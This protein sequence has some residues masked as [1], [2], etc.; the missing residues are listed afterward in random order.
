MRLKKLISGVLAGL[1]AISSIPFS[2]AGIIASAADAEKDVWDGTTDT[3]WYDSE[4]TEFHISTPEELAGLAE[5]VN[6]GKSMSGQT[7]V[8]DNDIYMN[9]VSKYEK[10]ESVAP[11]NSWTPIGTSDTY[12]F[13]GIFD[14]S[15]FSI[16]GLYISGSDYQ[17]SGLLGYTTDL[18]E[19]SNINMTYEYINNTYGNKC[20]AGGI[21]AYSKGKIDNCIFNGTVTSSSSSYGG[22]IAGYSTAEISNCTNNGTVTSSSDYNSYGGGIAGYSSAEI[23]NCTNSG[24]VTSSSSSSSYGGGIAGYSSANISNCANNGTITSSYG[25]GIVGESYCPYDAKEIIIS[26]VYNTG[27]VSAESYE[28]GIVGYVYSSSPSYKLTINNAYNIGKVSSA[29]LGG[30]KYSNNFTIINSSYLIGQSEQGCKG[31]TDDDEIVAKS[32]AKM[33]TKEFAES[34]GDAFKYVSS[35]YPVLTFQEDSEAIEGTKEEGY[36]IDWYDASLDEYHLSTAE[37]LIGLHKVVSSG[38]NLSEKTVYLDSDIVLNDISDYE[39]WETTAPANVWESIG[40]LSSGN[41]PFSG[42]FDGQGHSIIGL[43]SITGGLFAYLSNATVKN[44]ILSNEY[45]KTS[46]TCGGLANSSSSSTLDGIGVNGSISG[47]TAGGLVGDFGG[48]MSNCYNKAS[49]NGSDYSGGLTGNLNGTINTSYNIG[50]VT[51]SCEGGISGK[52]SSVTLNKA[53]YANAN[54][55]GI[56]SATSDSAIAK[57]DANMKKESFVTSLG[58]AFVY[59][60]GDYPKLAWEV[61]GG[62]EPTETTTEE[63]TVATTAKQTTAATTKATTNKTIVATTSTAAK[64]TTIVTTAT[65][66]ETTNKTT[67]AT[68]A[69]VTKKTTTITT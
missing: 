31:Y 37:E 63:T 58:D 34:L 2:S 17:Y 44:V 43:Y 57:S 8:L 49:V 5:L 21:T 6:D 9:D 10:W 7:F 29:I 42:T 66:K 64:T 53:Y 65:N 16:E 28:G 15:G 38:K 50:K 56:G 26:N 47:E 23:S 61:D 27:V 68:T 12:C 55:K 48:T 51:G 69:A 33:Q 14:G 41:K 67:V 11:T 18:S 45:V 3:S 54:T 20:Y 13:S 62:E 19:I 32:R 60:E 59:V 1:T 46:G 24:D 35:H 52:G 4:E 40:Y 30:S 22:G 36:N 39:N 25:G